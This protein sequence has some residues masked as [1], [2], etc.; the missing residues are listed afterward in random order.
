MAA[1]RNPPIAEV[2]HGIEPKIDFWKSEIFKFW[3]FSK[4]DRAGEEKPRTRPAE[5]APRLAMVTQ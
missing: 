2:K 4:S 5:M 1:P 3:S